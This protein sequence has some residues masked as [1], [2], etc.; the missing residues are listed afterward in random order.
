MDFMKLL[1]S[2]EELVFEALTWLILLPRTLMRIVLHPLCM[3]HYAAAEIAR[4]DEARF[5]DA[6]SPPL[7]LILCVLIAHLIDLALPAQPIDGAGSLASVIL[8]SEQT[9]LLYRS[10]AFGVWSLA[11]AMYFLVRSRQPV[12]RERLRAPL[13]EQCYLVAPFALVV[14]ASMS[15][16]QRGATEAQLAAAAAISLAAMAWFWSAQVIWIRERTGLPWWRSIV[17]GSVVLSIGALVNACVGY[18]LS[19][20]TAAGS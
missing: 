18:L 12:S 1:K 9:L 11:G 7:L 6:L 3:T 17:A 5:D 20:T 8:A 15:L 19:H 16:L 13:Y 4:D 2:F 14:S 10:I